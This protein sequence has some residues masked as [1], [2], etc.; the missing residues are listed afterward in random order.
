VNPVAV[1]FD[2]YGTLLDITCL[3]ERVA[4]YT[5]DSERFV[6]LWRDRQLALAFG[7]SHTKTYED[8]DELTARALDETADRLHVALEVAARAHLLDGWTESAF[9]SDVEPTIAA[10]TK[11]GFHT[12][13]LTNG[14]AR[15]ARMALDHAGI[16]NALDVVL[17]ADTVEGYK[18]DESVYRM[19]LDY[20]RCA[21]AD[22]VF[23]S[24]NDWDASG[25]ARIGFR[26]IWCNRGASGSRRPERTITD[27]DQL[28]AV[29]DSE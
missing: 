5:A 28:I 29:I 21:P 24:S 15:S 6:Q 4:P 17:T 16:L 14:T 18:P 1:V 10:L 9:Y 23:V 7:A 25:A 22:I 11:R 19:A 13:V 3:R 2:L 20:Y 8:F 26:S 27:L 12:A